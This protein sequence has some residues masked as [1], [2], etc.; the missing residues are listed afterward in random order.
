MQK[1][2]TNYAFIDAQNIHLCVKQDGWTLDWKNFWI[3]LREKFAVRKAYIFIGYLEKN[4]DLYHFLNE[5]GYSLV[6]KE[7]SQ[8]EGKIK[9][10]VDVELAV[11]SVLDLYCYSKAIIVSNDGDFSYL[12]NELLERQKLETVICTSPKAASGILKR[13]AKDGIFFLS[14][15]KHFLD[16]KRPPKDGR[17]PRLRGF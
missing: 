14:T 17:P 3:L 12:V 5:L 15:V 1:A 10:N 8:F 4:S 6:F 9:G 2:L 13:T 11:R 16:H 7:T